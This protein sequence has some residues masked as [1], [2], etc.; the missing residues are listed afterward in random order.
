MK[1]YY[2]YLDESGNF[3]G[4]SAE[5]SIVAGFVSGQELSE[6]YASGLMRAVRESDPRYASIRLEPF[7]AMEER[8]PHKGEFIAA[9]LERLSA[10]ASLV[11]FRNERGFA[12]VNSDITYLNVFAAG[13]VRLLVH[14]AK[15]T[16]DEILLKVFYARRLNVRDKEK[17]GSVNIIGQDNYQE[18]IAERLVLRLAQLPGEIKRRLHFELREGSARQSKLLMLADVV[19]FALRGGKNSLSGEEKE[20]IRRLPC[21]SL[22]V[23][24]NDAWAKI[25]N[26]L[27]NE[28]IAEAIY[29]WY[30]IFSHE[31]GTRYGGEFNDL[32][33]EKLRQLSYEEWQLQIMML[34]QNIARLIGE[35]QFGAAEGIISRLVQKLFPLLRKQEI[36]FIK[37]ELGSH[38][39]RL[40]VA[41]NQ[42][43]TVAADRAIAAFKRCFRE[44]ELTTEMVGAFISFKLREISHLKNIFAFQ[45]ALAELGILEKFVRQILDAMSMIDGVK[46]GTLKSETLCKI[47]TSRAFTWCCLYDGNER[48]RNEVISN[49]NSALSQLPEAAGG[50]R[51]Y[52]LRSRIEYLSGNVAEAFFWLEKALGKPG[53]N[54]MDIIAGDFSRWIFALMHYSIIM[55]RSAA[56]DRE[57]ADR[58]YVDWQRAEVTQWLEKQAVE[59]PLNLIW[60][61]LGSCKAQRGEAC[62]DEFQRSMEYSFRNIRNYTVYAMGLAAAAEYLGRL[63]AELFAERKGGLQEAWE[64]F[65]EQPLPQSMKRY[66]TDC[67]EGFREFSRLSGAE[68]QEKLL[69]AAQ[70]IPI[71]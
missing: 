52:M 27:V 50:E 28:Q 19:C 41:V 71:V 63:P 67:A 34:L 12:V 51:Q 10:E 40:T 15:E 7:H 25:R 57:L 23:M 3:K 2:L 64:H 68:Q 45:E 36:S 46:G 70:R 53:Q 20:R 22:N 29:S 35:R 56:I 24:E 60:W 6:E 65:Q 18:R 37:L 39:L 55:A 5:P 58:L 48:A 61:Q 13:I 32:L 30:G 1:E 8:S 26:L 31:L 59:Y 16:A 49:V 17:D 44:N 47:Y 9:V 21:L 54:T 4:Q 38:F 33:A 62:E 66:L 11:T 42:G 14:L 69:Q 43:D